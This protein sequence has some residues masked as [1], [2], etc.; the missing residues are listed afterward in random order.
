VND[1]VAVAYPRDAQT[2]QGSAVR[3]GNAA[4]PLLERHEVRQPLQRVVHVAQRVDDG[5]GRLPAE[6]LNF[7]VAVDPR[8][9]DVVEPA[10]DAR[11]VTHRLVLAQLD[12]V[13]AEEDGVPAQLRDAGLGGHARPRAALGKDHRH[14]P[15]DER[16][17]HDALPAHDVF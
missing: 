7:G 9:H 13:G 3:R 17:V 16:P 10:E 15:S 12:V 8:E 5:D 6:L 4:I 11:R 14:R 2:C 1:V